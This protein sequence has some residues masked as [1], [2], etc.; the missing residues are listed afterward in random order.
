MPLQQVLVEIGAALREDPDA[1]ARI[2]AEMQDE[3]ES[4]LAAGGRFQSLSLF[5]PAF[6]FTTGQMTV[7]MRLRSR[8]SKYRSEM[9]RLSLF[10][11]GR[12]HIFINFLTPLAAFR[13]P[14]EAASDSCIVMDWAARRMLK[15]AWE[16]FLR[17]QSEQMR[18]HLD[19]RMVDEYIALVWPDVPKGYERLLANQYASIRE[20]LAR[21]SNRNLREETRR[22][23]ITLDT[24]QSS[25]M[26]Q[27][28]A[29]TR[30][31][32]TVHTFRAGDPISFESPK[33]KIHTGLQEHLA[34][35]NK[36]PDAGVV[37]D[38]MDPET[39]D[40]ELEPEGDPHDAVDMVFLSRQQLN[41]ALTTFPEKGYSHSD[42]VRWKS[43]YSFLKA[44]GFM[45]SSQRGSHFPFRAMVRPSQWLT[46]IL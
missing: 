36:T 1:A 39:S 37:R 21:K 19:G 24:S 31:Q 23:A 5:R 12:M 25:A 28:T 32:K 22:T 45:C 26:Q 34:V 7:E 6:R 11:D 29:P 40:D 41:A 20:M 10:K 30:K 14:K 8:W 33:R 2:S 35:L 17:Y 43:M 15:S 42:Q 38:D 16:L 18:D 46:R 27:S 3:L 13:P 4:L 9:A 44:Y